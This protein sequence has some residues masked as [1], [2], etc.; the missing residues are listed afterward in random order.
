M[1]SY[2][3]PKVDLKDPQT[4]NRDLSNSKLISF[5][6][7]PV[8]PVSFTEMLPGDEV[9]LDLQAMIESF[10]MIGA[11]MSGFSASFHVYFE[12][13]SNLYG[14]MDNNTRLSPQ[15]VLEM[16]RWTM[17]LGYGMD[18][19]LTVEEQDQRQFDGDVQAGTTPALIA[20]NSI[21]PSSLADFM[22]SAVGYFGDVRRSR[23]QDY[24][25]LESISIARE[26]CADRA[27]AYLD[28]I[29]NYYVN[30]QEN[31]TFFLREGGKSFDVQNGYQHQ[32]GY[33]QI[34]LT[35]L[36]DFFRRL[37]SARTPS[38]ISGEDFLLQ[39]I[40]A[41][42]DLR[43]W[44]V[45]YFGSTNGDGEVEPGLLSA[46]HSGGLFLRTYRMDLLRGI[47][48]ES[49]GSYKSTA[50]VNLETGTVDYGDILFSSKLYDLI[51]RLDLTGGRFVDWI[52]TRWGVKA[53]G[54]PNRPIFLGSFSQDFGVRDVVS[55]TAGTQY[56]SDGSVASSSGAGQ[57]T[58]FANGRIDANG[59]RIK[60]RAGEYGIL[61][62]TFSLVP[63]VRYS[64]GFNIELFKTHFADIY[65][66]AMANLGWQDVL[67]GELS[68]IPEFSTTVTSVTEGFAFDQLLNFSDYSDN[69]AVVGKRVAWS[70]YMAK[71]PR[72]HGLFAQGE[73]L[74]YWA[75]NRVYT[76]D[77]K[78]VDSLLLA[79]GDPA[80]YAGIRNTLLRY[81]RFDATTYVRPDLWNHLFADTRLGAENFRLR[82][83]LDES[84]RRPIPK[85]EMPH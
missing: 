75:F 17:N 65:D 32:L 26:V 58:G 50:S 70:E 2:V 42:S 78:V 40:D 36:D 29:R 68:A 51:N 49:V 35:D 30:N 77:S 12:P 7:G 38:N 56:G 27:L 14:F 63:L 72:S 84:F 76:T 64:Q 71:I 67:Q 33:G 31:T 47:M 66:P 45:N 20:F 4:S 10:P 28:I 22:E 73:A 9:N 15:Q 34:S 85:R 21:K 55:P 16:P 1:A 24:D 57:Q 18:P 83:S 43:S 41:S 13:L 81:G 60:F 48:N 5:M 54:G 61:V 82:L 53:P 19:S 52:K 74:D 79:T 46:D 23:T 37:R 8:Y 11:P 25:Y 69:D 6:P 44:I 59:K 3:F 39:F 80:A 62:V